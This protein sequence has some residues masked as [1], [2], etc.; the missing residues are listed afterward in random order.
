MQTVNYDYSCIDGVFTDYYDFNRADI[1][2]ISQNLQDLAKKTSVLKVLESI[3]NYML[4]L[5][6]TNPNQTYLIKHI[7][8]VED[9]KKQAEFGLH[10]SNNF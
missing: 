5:L 1:F 9:A 10:P 6:K 7:E 8:I 2:D 3:Q 4:A